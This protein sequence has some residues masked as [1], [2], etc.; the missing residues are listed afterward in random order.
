MTQCVND[1][2]GDCLLSDLVEQK[3]IEKR[4]NSPAEQG[5]FRESE[6]DRETTVT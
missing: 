2:E 3:A 5:S 6:R 4:E 1:G